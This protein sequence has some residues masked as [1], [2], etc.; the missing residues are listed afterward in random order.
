ME[1]GFIITSVNEEPIHSLDEF[2]DA[3]V[4]AEGEITLEGFYKGQEEVF[5]YIFDKD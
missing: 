3:V 2:K 1:E 5:T 4:A